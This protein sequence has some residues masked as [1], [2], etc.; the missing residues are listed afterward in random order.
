MNKVHILLKDGITDYLDYIR[1]SEKCPITEFKDGTI[2]YY[3]AHKGIQ[4]YTIFK[5]DEYKK[6]NNQLFCENLKQML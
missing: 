1:L 3:N 5:S 2:V 6:K 4:Y